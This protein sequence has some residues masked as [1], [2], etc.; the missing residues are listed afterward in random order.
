MLNFAQQY[1]RQVRRRAIALTI[2]LLFMAGYGYHIHHSALLVPEDTV[3]TLQVSSG[4]VPEEVR[5][6]GNVIADTTSTISLSVDANL[7]EIYVDEGSYIVKGELIAKFSSSSLEDTLEQAKANL[8][9]AELAVT[10]QELQMSALALEIERESLNTQ[11]SVHNT[12]NHYDALSKLN[13]KGIVSGLEFK[14]AKLDFESATSLLELLKRQ[15]EALMSIE[16]ERV[17]IAQNKKNLALKK[18]QSLQFYHDSLEIYAPIGGVVTGLTAKKGQQLTKG[19]ALLTLSDTNSFYVTAAMPQTAMGKISLNDEVKIIVGGNQI[20]GVV[21]GLPQSIVN[22]RAMVDITLPESE[23]LAL[24]QSVAIVVE[25]ISDT[26]KIYAKLPEEHSIR[27]GD[28]LYVA[29]DNNTYHKRIG[30][31]VSFFIKQDRT[32]VFSAG[33]EKNDT[34]LVS[35]PEYTQTENLIHL[36]PRN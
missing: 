29:L 7:D 22:G 31:D 14:K 27:E 9:A 1:N 17:E 28:G 12:R 2:G 24:N 20:K 33:V 36:I 15:S 4:P 13:E 18:Y 25:Y 21:S 5:G 32:I 11:Q 23:K 8:L 10:E 19:S 3:V 35:Y 30:D 16:Q 34:I 26:S 6:A